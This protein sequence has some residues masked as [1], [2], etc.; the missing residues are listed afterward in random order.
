MKIKRKILAIGLVLML[1]SISF[2]MVQAVD[3]KYNTQ[4]NE[5]II[6][7]IGTINEGENSIIETTSLSE[8]QLDELEIF[9][10]D[11][12]EK[13]ESA[14]SMEEINIIFNN[15]DNNYLLKNG[16]LYDLIKRIMSEIKNI[17][18]GMILKFKQ[19]SDHSFVISYG[20]SYRLNLFKTT[21]L[22][23]IRKNLCIWHYSKG[24]T[25]IWKPDVHKALNDWQ[26]GFMSNFNGMYMYITKRFPQ[27]CFTFF[28]GMPKMINGIPL[29]FRK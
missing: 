18:Y 19:L 10:S 29:S 25:L 16:L 1:V 24:T 17:V 11:I 13:I 2:S 6:I 26:I 14:E 15:Y 21:Q 27:K 12:V 23:K 22:M 7:E 5:S 8:D 4:N 20:H 3:T 28:V 9:L